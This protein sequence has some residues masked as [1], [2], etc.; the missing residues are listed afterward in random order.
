MV[1][2]KDIELS[3]YFSSIFLKKVVFILFDIISNVI[4]NVSVID[5]Q[6]NDISTKIVELENED[7]SIEDHIDTIDNQIIS[8]NTYITEHI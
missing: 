2:T 1:N 8:I 4:D 5:S 7:T 6:L 3:L